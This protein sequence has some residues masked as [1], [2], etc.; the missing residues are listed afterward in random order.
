MRVLHVIPSL[1]PSSGGPSFALPAMARALSS[2]DVQVIAAST[3]DDG[4]GKHL[5]DI[6]LGQ[7]TPQDGCGAIFFRKQTEFYKA[8]LPLRSWLRR[9]V[10]EFDAV[11]IHAVFSFA[12]LAAG[13]AAA[14]AGVPYVVRPLG[15]LNRWGMEN[16]RKL[17]KALSFRLLDLPMLRKA[18][19][20]HYTSRM[21]MDD[22]ARFGLENLQRVIPIGM[23][24]T[25]FDAL[26]AREVFSARF[27]ETAGTRN[28]LFLSRIDEKKGIDLLLAAFA[29][30]APDRPDIRLIICGG[31][32]P[33]L[34]GRLQAQAVSLGLAGRVIWAGQ[35]T[36]EFRLAAFSAA[37]LFVLPSHS[38]N[39]GIAL[40]EAMAAGLP[41]LSTDQVAL[42]ADAARDKAVLLTDREPAAIAAKLEALLDSPE[43][44][45]LLGQSARI[46]SRCDYSLPA[47]G[48]ALHGLYCEIVKN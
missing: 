11:H 4:R 8:S 3:D 17:V 28:I 22:A 1:S 7:I 26:P 34:V 23:D 9:H 39:F 43:E 12:S 5:Q 2:F 15:V 20:M 30:L 16:R 24:L 13:H 40:L 35:V 44:R 32:D 45:Q 38:E 33:A 37:E 21:E 6:R 27:Q 29:R 18:A 47:M 41:C 10:K 19:A 36:G 31:G 48:K 46:L 25:P 14:S 42:A